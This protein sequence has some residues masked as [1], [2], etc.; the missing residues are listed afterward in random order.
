LNQKFEGKKKRPKTKSR[1]KYEQRQQNSVPKKQ[2]NSK[3]TKKVMIPQQNKTRIEYD[4]IM[5]QNTDMHAKHKP[6]FS[7]FIRS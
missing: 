4:M 7:N 5:Q 2:T 6:K 3:K 1:R